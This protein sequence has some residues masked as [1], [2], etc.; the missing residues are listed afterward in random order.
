MRNA[1]DPTPRETSVHT[2]KTQQA[3]QQ[4]APQPSLASKERRYV[5]MS[6]MHVWRA[7]QLHLDLPVTSTLEEDRWP[8]SIN[9][10]MNEDWEALEWLYTHGVGDSRI[11][12]APGSSIGP[13]HDGSGCVI[14]H[15][16][17]NFL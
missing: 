12:G 9:P 11:V 8:K 3:R 2:I 15:K 5:P 14:S 4:N 1:S 13:H 6:E 17:F 7:D 10:T 16:F